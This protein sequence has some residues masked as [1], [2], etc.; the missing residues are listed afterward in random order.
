[1]ETT[2][3]AAVKKVSLKAIA[4]NELKNSVFSLSKLCKLC[5]ADENKI[6]TNYISEKY[7][8][9]NFKAS[10]ITTKLVSK[11]AK[12]NELNKVDKQGLLIAK[13]ELFSF[14]FIL[15]IVD[16]HIKASK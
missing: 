7:P 6:I 10:Q 11:Y 9:S 8:Q 1:M 3:T 13:K 2:K 4:N 16:R 5:A 14:W 15:S 12:F